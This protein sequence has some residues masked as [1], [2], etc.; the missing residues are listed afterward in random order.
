MSTSTP[1]DPPTSS[2]NEEFSKKKLSNMQFR[3]TQQKDTEQPFTGKFDKFFKTGVY[4]CIV[5]NTELFKSDHKFN[6]GCGWPAFF[7]SIDPSKIRKERDE[8]YGRIRT[9]V[10]CAKCDA[11]LGHIFDDG[12]KP[13]R[14]RYCINSA[15]MKFISKD[16]EIIE[17]RQD[18]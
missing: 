12:P 17:D 11:H 15:A 4:Q 1:P 8:S 16:G 13:T 3:V 2:Q 5:C 14:L 7:D 18:N 9:E 10:L 6:S